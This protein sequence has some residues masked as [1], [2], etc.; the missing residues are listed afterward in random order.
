MK[1]NSE[2]EGSM[3]EIVGLRS[4]PAA[5]DITP[6]EFKSAG[7]RLIDNIA[8][9]L[10]GIGKRKV[11]CA[12]DPATA[13]R[14]VGTLERLPEEGSSAY[15]ILGNSY[16]LL[17]ENSLFNGHPRFWGYITSSAAPIGVLGELLA[18]AINANLGSWRLSPAATEIEI[19]TIRWIA[20]LIGYPLECGGI[21]VSGGN[22]A[23]FVCF[24]AART[25]AAGWDV[26][27]GGLRDES[28]RRLTV[29][30]SDQ[31]HTW[32]EKAADM[33]GL[34]TRSVR[35]IRTDK[36]SRMDVGLL[37]SSIREDIDSGYQPMMVVGTAGTVSTGA[38]DPLNEIASLCRESGIWFHVDGAYGALAAAAQSIP[39]DLRGLILADSVA[40]DPHKWLYAPLEAGCALVRDP[41]ALKKSFTYHPPY[42]HFGDE[43]TN[44][45]DYGPQNSRG[46]RAL[47]VWL[48]FK[49]VGG[50]GYRRMIEEDILLARRIFDLLDQ[51]DEFEACSHSL[52]ITTFRYIPPDLKNRI[53]D[54]EIEEYLNR[55][56][57]ELLGRLERSGELFVSNAIIEG[58]FLLRAC[59][60]NF[61]TMLNDVDALPGII[62]EE[63]RKA[64]SLLRT[65]ASES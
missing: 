8:E 52:S 23:N 38:V 25:K 50:A 19:Q 2:Y 1:F 40:V 47:K 7:Y 27:N 44:F 36:D 61:R 16:K 58:K 39:D 62:A 20:E 13:K 63:G 32:M 17:S 11:T 43:T 42:Y 45:V 21:L 28:G 64:D 14:L 54:V 31:V 51:H 5:I 35:I 65:G 37:R 57:E 18:A 34:G 33:S 29:Y 46:F 55:L 4:E 9:L 12:P 59:I 10:A 24:L 56:N 22:M 41:E 60:V 53:G 3:K 26:R 30:A 49:Q 6:D 48:A 15:E